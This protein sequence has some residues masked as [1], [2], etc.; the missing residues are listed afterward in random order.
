MKDL[1]HDYEK[2]ADAGYQDFEI[3]ALQ[4]IANVGVGHAATALSQLLHRR[5]DMSVPTIELVHFTQLGTR[6][7]DSLE[8]VVSSILVDSIEGDKMFNLL[9]IFDKESSINI[10]NI[11]KSGE[12]PE[13]LSTLDE[14]SQS[15]ILETGNI[16]LLHTISAI[17]QFAESAYFP[18]TPQLSIDMIGSILDEIISR[19]N[20]EL[21][22]ESFLLIECNIFTDKES[23]KGNIII[24]PNESGIKFIMGKL[25]GEDIYETG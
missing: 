18:K 21:K 19:Q 25:Y 1:G 4:E 9:L 24:L 10:I 22:K 17:N 11:L 8:S 15:I 5:V 20:I 12:P 13:S 23:L 3:E 7:A 2:F 14:V 16:L 6:I